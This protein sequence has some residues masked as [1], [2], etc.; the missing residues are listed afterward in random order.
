MMRILFGGDDPGARA[1][2]PH[3]FRVLD[4]E[5]EAKFL[6]CGTLKKKVEE[7]KEIR[8][9]CHFC[10][11]RCK[12]DR[13]RGKEGFCRV[14]EP[15]VS[16]EFLHV[17]EEPELVPSYTLFFSGC[18]FKCCFCQNWDISQDPKRGVYNK[19]ETVAKMI[20]DIKGINVNWVGGDPAPN[21]D[22][23]LE[24][25][26]Q[27]NRSIPQIW[28]SNMYL[29][30]ESMDLLGGV[31]D[32]YLTD[33]KYGPKDCATRLSDA[34]NYWKVITR[35]HLLA[36]K[37]GADLIIRHLVLPGHFEC[38]TKPILDWISKNLSHPRVNVMS[39]YHPDYKS[40]QI[41]GLDQKLSKE[42]YR[43]AKNYA[44]ELG[45]SLTR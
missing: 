21:L 7:A 32:L 27:L 12:I 34:P 29:T 45:L 31:I 2:L 8:K 3:Y 5:G 14:L 28:N 42:E 20:E 1:A 19:P 43:Q 13:S 18:T 35:N 39:Q 44:E 11:R 41:I 6:N 23:I 17:G 15:R 38:C 9:S 30:K 22:F 36:E 26:T 4:G 33:F 16:S 25:L 24:V 37:Q 10:E 40:M